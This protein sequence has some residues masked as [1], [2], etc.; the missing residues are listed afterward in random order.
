MVLFRRSDVIVSDLRG[1]LNTSINSPDNGIFLLPFQWQNYYQD[2]DR[3][4]RNYYGG[5]GYQG[6]R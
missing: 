2:R 6:Y 1:L 4:Y 5:G 3:Y